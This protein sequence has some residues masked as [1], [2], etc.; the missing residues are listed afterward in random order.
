MTSAE[1][2]VSTFFP[3]FAR[4]SVAVI[5]MLST[6]PHGQ[7]LD[8]QPGPA[9]LLGRSP[10]TSWSAFHPAPLAVLKTH[11]NFFMT[12]GSTDNPTMQR[13]SETELR[14]AKIC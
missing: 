4:E 13:A 8:A 6:T 5:P 11:C 3:K 9:S 10:K 7:L 12:T 14:A 1:I 2:E